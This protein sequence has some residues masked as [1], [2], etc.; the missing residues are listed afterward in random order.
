MCNVQCLWVAS[1]CMFFFTKTIFFCASFALATSNFPVLS[2][3]R[4]FST[5][6]DDVFF[7]IIFPFFLHLLNAFTLLGVSYD[8]FLSVCVFFFS[9]SSFN[10]CSCC[11]CF[12]FFL[13]LYLFYCWMWMKFCTRHETSRKKDFPTFARTRPPDT[14]ISKSVASLLLAYNWTQVKSTK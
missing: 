1:H 12:V 5:H 7:A 14:Q 10:F 8:F 11:C 4:C 3:E 9:F 2:K 6:F 13:C